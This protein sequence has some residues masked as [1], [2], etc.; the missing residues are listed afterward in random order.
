MAIVVVV[1]ATR[2]MMASPLMMRGA[3]E[4]KWVPFRSDEYL[5]MGE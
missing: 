3:I 4:R 1:M 5:R 2:T